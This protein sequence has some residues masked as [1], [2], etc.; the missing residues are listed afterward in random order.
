MLLRQVENICDGFLGTL[1]KLDITDEIMLPTDDLVKLL[2]ETYNIEE[3][4]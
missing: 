2:C 4:Y 1:D 3:E